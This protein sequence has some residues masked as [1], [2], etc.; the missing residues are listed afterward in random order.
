MKSNVDL[1]LST[2]ISPV[3]FHD[4]GSTPG[5]EGS[6][7]VQVVAK[8]LQP[9]FSD[10]TWPGTKIN[11]VVHDHDI[12]DRACATAA[13]NTMKKEHSQKQRKN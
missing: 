10:V 1:A 12:V 8:F 4:I 13:N 6:W 11:I 5:I 2:W 9:N 7:F 3:P